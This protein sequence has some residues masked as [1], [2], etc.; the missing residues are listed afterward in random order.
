M[1]AATPIQ[2]VGHANV[3]DGVPI[4]VRQDVHEVVLVCHREL[5][6]ST[7]GFLDSASLRS[8]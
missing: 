8:E 2:I 5:S 7:S 4:F 6:G 3:Q 1:L